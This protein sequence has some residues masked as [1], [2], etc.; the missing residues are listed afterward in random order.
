MGGIKITLNN[1]GILY[2]ITSKMCLSKNTYKESFCTTPSPCFARISLTRGFK[3]DHL[4]SLV[5]VKESMKLN[6]Y[7]LIDLKNISNLL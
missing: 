2:D 4:L 3:K 1:L 6:I 7:Q 5:Q